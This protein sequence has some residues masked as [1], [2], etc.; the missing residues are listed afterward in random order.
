[1]I[2]EVDWLSAAVRTF[3]RLSLLGLLRLSFLGSFGLVPSVLLDR[4]QSVVQLESRNHRLQDILKAELTCVALI[5]VVGVILE[6]KVTSCQCLNRIL[7]CGSLRLSRDLRFLDYFFQ[8]LRVD[9]AA[10]IEVVIVLVIE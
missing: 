4:S 7:V 6:F 10:L 9:T 3:I 2:V 8:G 5:G 1:L